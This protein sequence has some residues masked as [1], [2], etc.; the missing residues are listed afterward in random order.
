[1]FSNFYE[2]YDRS[3]LKET[4]VCVWGGVTTNFTLL[5]LLDY[6]MLYVLSNIK[7][8]VSKKIPSVTQASRKT[9]HIYHCMIKY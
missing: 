4:C 3:S 1:M 7:S 8:V 6:D 2:I 5:L 9:K